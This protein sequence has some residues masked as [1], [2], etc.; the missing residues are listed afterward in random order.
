[1]NLLILDFSKIGMDIMLRGMMM[2][3]FIMLMINVLILGFIGK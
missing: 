2:D 3:I 1:M